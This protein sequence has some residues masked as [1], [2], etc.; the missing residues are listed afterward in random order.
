MQ[1][2]SFKTLLIFP[3]QWI[4]L[5]PHFSICSLAGYLKGE[6]M[7]VIVEDINVKFYRHILTPRFLDYSKA[8]AENAFEYLKHKLMLTV[9][10]KET[11]FKARYES[12]RFLEIEKFLEKGLE[13]FNRVKKELPQAISTFDNRDRFYD[14]YHLIKAFITVDKALE[15]ISL[16]YFPARIKF[17]DFYT[18]VYPLTIEGIISFSEDRGENLFYP[19]LEREVPLLL[20]H[21]PDLIGISINSPTQ[22]YP[23]LTLARLLKKSKRERCHLNIGGNYF[24]RLPEVIS[25]C[26]EFFRYFAESVITGEGEKPLVRLIRALKSGKSLKTVPCFIYF[27]ENEYAKPQCTLK[28]PPFS[29]N[30]LHHQSLDQIITDN[31]FVPD[32]VIS[33]QSSKGCYWQKCTFC[34][35]DF[36]IHP[37]VKLKGKLIEEIKFLKN[38]YGIENFEFIDESILPDYMNDLARTIIEEKIEIFWFSNARTETAFTPELLRQLKQS[39]LLMLLWGVESGNM[40]I[41]RLINKGI[42]LERRLEI[43]RSASEAGIWNFAYIFFGFPSETKDEAE[44]TINMIRNNIDIIHSYGRSIFSLGKHA[45]L[46]EKAEK[47]GIVKFVSDLQAFSSDMSYESSSGMNPKE[48][49]EMADACKHLCALA[50]G[51]P[52]WMYLRYREILFLYIKK[53]G[54]GYVQDFKFDMKQREEIHS[55]Y[56]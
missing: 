15:I 50:Y 31:Y 34:D 26:S 41:M 33:L 5:N 36:G 16:P 12:A 18:P 7:E 23:G 53:Y 49:I 52:L 25:D 38:T 56:R 32:P 19:F 3:P 22:V 46:R 9:A 24:T 27:D 43:L 30:E 35:T 40:R 42:D 47:L 14:P 10:R 51:E 11:D 6:G 20:K 48:V 29:L 8:R 1:N 39:G 44:E 13:H 28:E 21:E 55:M 37:D 4:P 2:K 17:N 45:K 54:R